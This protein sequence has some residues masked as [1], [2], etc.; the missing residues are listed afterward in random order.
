MIGG[1]YTIRGAGRA[2]RLGT[3]HVLSDPDGQVHGGLSLD[4]SA[5]DQAAAHRLSDA[6]R[7]SQALGLPTLLR[8]IDQAAE[9]NVLWLIS[10]VPATPTVSQALSTGN[11]IPAAVTLQLAVDCGQ[12]LASLHEAGL[13]HGDVSG[14]TVILGATGVVALAEC[15]YAHALAGTAPG[16]GNDVNGWVALLRELAKP[17]PDDTAKQLLLASANQAESTGG[18]AGLTAALTTLREKAAQIPGF[19]DRG[20][21]ALVSATVSSA[22]AAG[23]ASTG[24]ASTAGGPAGTFAAGAAGAGAAGVGAAGGTGAAGAG[25]AGAAAAGGVAGL[26]SGAAVGYPGGAGVAASPP[27]ANAGSGAGSPGAYP[28]AGASASA[29]PP[30]AYPGAGSASSGAAGSPPGAVKPTSPELPRHVSPPSGPVPAAPPGVPPYAPPQNYGA[31]EAT[32]ILPAG[33]EGHALTLPPQELA[34]RLGNLARE[35]AQQ[36]PTPRLTPAP[37]RQG[38]DGVV[39]FGRGV[40][41]PSAPQP[42]AASVQSPAWQTGTSAYPT[43]PKRR[44]GPLI[45]GAITF[46]LTVALVAAVGWVLY[47]Q[48]STPLAV[49]SAQA[50]A[51]NPP[52]TTPETRC[53]VAVNVVGTITTNG[54]RGT[55][56]YEWL[57]DGQSTGVLTHNVRKGETA[58]QLPLVWTISGKGKHDAKATL[59]ILGPQVTET[60]AEFT[61]NCP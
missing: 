60:V 34:T 48:Y 37:P 9:G 6:I 27:G 59:K 23:P 21:L 57:K 54:E 10:A 29:S 36:N 12:T 20:S 18:S 7:N 52:G 47:G 28:G 39:R 33:Q 61:Y 19:A 50:A 42:A 46:V 13:A 16:P 3:W 32:A 40:A 11:P 4:P 49:V 41:T 43:K 58:V 53:N 56:T 44:K 2:G 30:S 51:T 38:E 31:G 24:P 26:A 8:L 17:R 5:L 15:G 14:D 22:F 1:K 25:A 35:S 45:A 55:I